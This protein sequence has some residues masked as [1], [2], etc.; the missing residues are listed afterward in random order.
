MTLCIT[1]KGLDTQRKQTFEDRIIVN[2]IQNMKIESD[3]IMK[4]NNTNIK[5][6]KID[7]FFLFERIKIILQK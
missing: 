6:S 3:I 7:N 4:K 1:H 2:K 5:A